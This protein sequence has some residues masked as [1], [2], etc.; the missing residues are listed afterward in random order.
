MRHQVSVYEHR[1]LNPPPPPPPGSFSQTNWNPPPIIDYFVPPV[2]QRN[3]VSVMQKYWTLSSLSRF[4]SGSLCSWSNRLMMLASRPLSFWK[5]IK[6]GKCFVF[7]WLP[8]EIGRD[9]IFASFVWNVN[10]TH[11]EKRRRP[12][13]LQICRFCNGKWIFPFLS[14]ARSSKGKIPCWLQTGNSLAR[15]RI[16][17]VSFFFLRPADVMAAPVATNTEWT[18][19]F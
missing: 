4:S 15:Q 9:E 6:D 1:N 18:N 5:W 3:Y 17:L 2:N 13:K 14:M 12:S 19:A 8:F 16:F 7:E 10:R 11:V